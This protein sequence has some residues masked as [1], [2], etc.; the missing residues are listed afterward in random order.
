[1]CPIRFSMRPGRPSPAAETIKK[2]ESVTAQAARGKSFVGDASPEL[3]ALALADD[4][5]ADQVFVP[6]G[7]DWELPIGAYKRCG[8]PT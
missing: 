7:Q 3:I 4:Y 6:K 1:M 2:G 8:G 5:P